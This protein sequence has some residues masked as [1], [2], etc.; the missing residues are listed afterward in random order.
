VKRREFITLLGGT[1]AAWPLAARAQQPG[2]MRR[3]GMLMLYAESDR[4][5]QAFVAAFR[6]GLQK[7]GWAEARNIRIDTRWA[8]AGDAVSRQR[9]AQ[10]IVA[11]QPDLILANGTPS[12]AVLQQQTATIPIIFANVTDPVGSGFVA[13]FPRPGGNVTGFTN[14]EPTMAGKWLELLKEIAPRVNRVAFLFNPATAPYTESFLNPFKAAATS[15]AVEVI[16]VPVHD[17]SELETVVAVQAREPNG[18]LIV[19]TDGFMN[20][21]RVEVTSLAARY[22]LP[23]VYPY[24]LFAEL[25]GLLSYGSDLLDNYRRAASYADHILKG[26]KPS[27]L[28]VQA[29]VKFE[30]VI[31]LKTAKALGLDV[32]LPLQQ[33][34]DELIE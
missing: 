16:A 25:G 26:E 6:E 27:N 22:R 20:V 9:F 4:E 31:N 18:G 10:E 28:P 12:T 29:P 5:G 3:I 2:G 15:F 14:I 32:P 11:L 24:R 19:M 21:H 13:S 17:T 30:L 33:R 8:P 7:L 1:A 23:A 34:A